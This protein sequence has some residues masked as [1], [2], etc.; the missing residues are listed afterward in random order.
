MNKNR[1]KDN[2]PENF[3]GFKIGLLQLW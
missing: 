1:N 3:G 2:I